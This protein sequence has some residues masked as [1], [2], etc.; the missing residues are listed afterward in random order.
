[1]LCKR[2]G[3]GVLRRTMFVAVIFA[4]ASGA[5]VQ[6]PDYRRPDVD[7]P[8][9]FR[10]GTSPE[11]QPQRLTEAGWWRS[12]GD[13]NLDALVE[14]A[15]LNNRDLRV[16]TA[17][18]DEFDA[19]LAG[20]KAQAFPQIGY[21][22]SANRSRASE[23]K[24]PNFVDPL[25]STFSAVL[26][27]SWE[28]DLWGRIRRETEA[29]RANL[30][31]TEEARRGVMLTIISS[32]VGSYVTLI[33]L[34]ERLRIAQSNLEGRRQWVELFNRRLA[35]GY[36]SDFE[37]TQAQAEYES[38]AAAIPDLRQAIA[39]QEDA[40]S[41]LLGQ[42]PRGVLRDRTLDTLRLPA[43]PSGLP[44]D[45]LTQ[46]PDILQAEHQLHASNALIGAARA[47]Y[48]PRIT[49]TGLAGFASSA[50]GR[51][52]TGPARTWSFTGD[53]AGPIFTGGGIKAAN[54]QAEARRDQSLAL[55]EKAIQNAFR[56]VDDS[57]AEVRNSRDLQVIL[58][59]RVQSLQEGVR[60]ATLRYDNG[61]TDYINVLD[62][63]RG[64]YNAQLSLTQARGDRY[65]AVISLY[66]AL[67]GDWV[68]A[69]ASVRQ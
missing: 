64:L 9:N 20:T 59:R 24:I 43:V 13:P 49:L 61:Y 53:V 18:V 50:L 8:P 65:R 33:D 30:L 69:S 11:L 21:D 55:Y 3:G 40:L 17:R 51:L 4:L 37:M 28:I 14:T 23:Q 32:V 25:S 27:A 35:R 15:L 5:C 60:L 62:T 42:N 26:L 38:T 45:L 52:F 41:V 47:L 54:R 12:M 31:A 56:D 67:G 57:L 10:F 7:I 16:A 39:T 63:E 44:S 34:D 6:G 48:F 46:R 66:R 29:A 36:I 19:I 22:L 1:M 2:P 58:E 68:Q